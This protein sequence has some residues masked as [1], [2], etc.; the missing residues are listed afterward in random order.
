MEQKSGREESDPRDGRVA[1]VTC[2]RTDGASGRERASMPA[3]D[4]ERAGHR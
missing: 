2:D 1:G 3:T 4:V